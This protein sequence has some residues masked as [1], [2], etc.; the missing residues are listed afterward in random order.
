MAHEQENLTVG[1]GEEVVTDGEGD[2]SSVEAKDDAAL[3][4]S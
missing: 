1:R 2:R 4:V 3:L